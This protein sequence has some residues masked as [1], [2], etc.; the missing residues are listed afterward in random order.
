MAI[1]EINIHYLPV[2]KRLHYLVAHIYFRSKVGG[3]N[4]TN[5]TISSHFEVKGLSESTIEKDLRK[6]LEL[7]LIDIKNPGSAGNKHITITEKVKSF[8]GENT[9]RIMD[10]ETAKEV[11][12]GR[13]NLRPDTVKN[14]DPYSKE[15]RSDTVKN[16]GHNRNRKET[17][18][19]N[20]LKEERENFEKLEITINGY[21]SFVEALKQ[22]N[23]FESF[24]DKIQADPDTKSLK[25]ET[26]IKD[27]ADK[28]NGHIYSDAKGL[29]DR[30]YGY[31]KAKLYKNIKS[32]TGELKRIQGGKM[33][34]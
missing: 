27:F 25:P 33:I 3:C 6:C 19:I 21:Q 1:H 22:S 24:N 2:P 14:Y 28:N 15:L 29:E 11:F 9:Q 4:E 34:G 10:R 7:G 23:L 13:K 32:L 8:L 17:Y 12:E 16:Y 18:K 20:S 30:F 5:K 26:I 31:M